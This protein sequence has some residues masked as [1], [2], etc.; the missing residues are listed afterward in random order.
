MNKSTLRQRSHGENKVTIKSEPICTV[1]KKERLFTM[2]NRKLSFRTLE[3]VPRKRQET[4]QVRSHGS[5]RQ[6]VQETTKTTEHA[7]ATAAA[8]E[9]GR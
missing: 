6:S 9:L 7:E 1:A 4:Q 3:G 8:V 2:W 5:L